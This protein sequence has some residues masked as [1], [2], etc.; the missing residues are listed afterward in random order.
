MI[1]ETIKKLAK[2]DDITHEEMRETMS[3]I[4]DG[5]TRV[6]DTTEFLRD[7]TAKG[8][9]DCELL[10]MLESMEEH[11][12]SIRPRC[13]GRM[14]DVCGTGGDR[15]RT[16]NVSTTAAF[17]VA[18]S[19]VYVAKHGNRSTT[20]I[21][22]SADIFEYF[23]YDLNMDPEKVR[24]IIE[25]FRIGFMFAQKFHPSMRNV[26]EARKAVGT[27][28]AFNLLGPLSNPAGVKDQLV[29]V[30]SPDYLRRVINI[31]RSRGS[32]NAI[33]VISGDG[34]DELSTTSKNKVCEMSSGKIREFVLDPEELGLHRAP[35][36]EI[37]VSTKE[38]S[39]R[40]FVSVLNGTA[41]KAMIEVTALNAAAGLVVGGMADT[42]GDGLGVALETIN[43]GK[44]FSLL[45]DF[46]RHCGDTGKLE[47]MA[48]N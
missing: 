16:F 39:F 6:E 40:S 11:A 37:Q 5:R 14:I 47:E 22:G 3:E 32:E 9:S 7:L 35:I 21:S 15:M 45:R 27:R 34:L 12:I 46:I 8:E 48:K 36:S 43:G 38:E 2:G 18:A 33:T 44:S 19:G 24:D 10:A 20:G 1:I 41:K 30:F 26:A 25:R 42:I 13:S 28:T 29:G 31:L 23:G 4:F 17:V